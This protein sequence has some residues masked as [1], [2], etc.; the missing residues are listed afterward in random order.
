LKKD[1]NG[2]SR[3]EIILEGSGVITEGFLPV[4]QVKMKTGIGEPKKKVDKN[5][6]LRELLPVGTF[7]KKKRKQEKVPPITGRGGTSKKG[8]LPLL[9]VHTIFWEG[10]PPTIKR[11]EKD[12]RSLKKPSTRT[13]KEQQSFGEKRKQPRGS[14]RGN[15]I[16]TLPS[17]ILKSGT[18]GKLPHFTEGIHGGGKRIGEG[19]GA[20]RVEEGGFLLPF[21]NTFYYGKLRTSEEP[22]PRKGEL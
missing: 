19:S 2:R 12:L 3:K 7:T 20:K 5:N 18:Y 11:E 4:Y 9:R 1:S 10:K 8:G 16:L 22:I 6:I 17:T 21:P 14:I 13:G 15:S